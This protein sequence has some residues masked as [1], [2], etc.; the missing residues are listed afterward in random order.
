RPEHVE[1]FEAGKQQDTEGA[2]AIVVFHR[3]RTSRGTIRPQCF[4][5]ND[6]HPTDSATR[7]SPRGP[8]AKAGVTSPELSQNER[9]DA[10]VAIVVELDRRID[11]TESLKALLGT[12]SRNGGDRE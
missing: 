3:S 1:Q 2:A 8:T 10:A 4:G 9:E 11:P 7:D 5:G 6:D 12:L